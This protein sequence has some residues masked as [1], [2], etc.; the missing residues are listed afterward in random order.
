[1]RTA[2]RMAVAAVLGLG[3]AATAFAHP[4]EMGGAMGAGMMGG[5]GH[6]AMGP[7]AMGAAQLMTPDERTALQEKMRNAK[8]P[9]ERQKIAAA[10][11][12]EM[13]R[14]A[15]EKGIALPGPHGPGMGFGPGFQAQTH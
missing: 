14:R 6:G 8:T 1:V 10:N 11:R 12:A 13:E 15:K 4:G 9:E 7:E 3:L 5:M 2:Y